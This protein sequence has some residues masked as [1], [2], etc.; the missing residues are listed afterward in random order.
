MTSP[1]AKRQRT[2]DASIT[3]SSIWYKDGSVVL[4]A[5]N[6]QFRVHWSFLSQNS[7]FFRDLEN[8]PQPPEQ[9]TVDGCP[10]VELPDNADDVK[11]L[12]KALYNPAIFHQKALDFPYIASFIRLGRKYEFKDLFHIALERLT[13]EN[14][15][16]LEAFDALYYPPGLSTHAGR[17]QPTRITDY[18]GVYHDILTLARENELRSLLPWAYVC[19][20][21]FNGLPR[22]DGTTSLLSSTD[23]QL[24]IIGRDKLLRAQ[25]SPDKTF[26]WLVPS[27]SNANGCK[28]HE[29]CSRSRESIWYSFATSPRIQY[30]LSTPKFL[31]RLPFCDH[32]RERAKEGMTAGRAKM[33]E[34]LPS[35]FGLP[36]WNELKSE[37]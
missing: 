19:P 21:I 7:S 25:C 17:G 23:T 36:P 27:E 33:W 15:A 37:L 32:C 6:T 30:A 20:E 18:P 26:G 11:Y 2:E 28:H 5:Q 16:T 12:L 14:P 29:I 4:Q 8:L 3:R 35:M 9:P 13:D 31:T 10:V 22:P 1:P 24:C 34:A